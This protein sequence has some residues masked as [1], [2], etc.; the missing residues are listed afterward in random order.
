[1]NGLAGRFVGKRVF[2]TGGARGIGAAAAR[3]FHAEGATVVVGARS[4]ESAERFLAKHG[5]DRFAAVA[6]DLSSQN[7]CRDVVQ[8]AAGILGGLDVLV[9]SAGVFADMPFED[10]TQAHWD[11]TIGINLGGGVFLYS[12]GVPFLTGK[13]WQRSKRGLRCGVDF[14]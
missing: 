7:A 4:G 8:R 2:V 6:G 11:E 14:L 10:V 3:A 9:N 1:M 5:R 12:G 13:P